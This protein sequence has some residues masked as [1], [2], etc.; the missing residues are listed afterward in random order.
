MHRK[1]IVLFIA[2][3][4]C[5]ACL[6]VLA[7]DVPVETY[8]LPNGL[9]VILHVDHKL[10]QATI[11]T[12]FRVGSKDE[13]KG[14]TG[15]AHLFEHLMF[16][17]TKRVP[18]GQFDV[19]M[20]SGG[21]ANNA[22]TSS[23]R[24]N[25]YS[26]GPSSLLPTLLWLD[27]DRMEGL[28]KAMTQEKLDLQR[29][30]VLNERRQS[31]ENRPYGKAWLIIPEALFPPGHP[32][33][34][35]VIG[36]PKD[37]EAATL[38]DVKGFFSTYYVPGNASLVV[39]GDFDKAAV[40]KVIAETFGAIPAQPLPPHKTAPPV[41]LDHEVRR[42]ATDKVKYPRI[43]LVWPSPRAYADGDAQMTLAAAILADG[44]SGRLYKR[45]V[46]DDRIAQNVYVYQDSRDLCSEFVIDVTAAQGADLG[47][48]KHAV[49]DEL[50]QFKKDG[51]T[52]AEMKRVKA[53]AEA[54]FLRM[55]ESL[56]RRADMLNE[57]Y[58][59]FGQ[60]NSFKRV[61][62][63]YTSA[64]ATSVKG[65]AGKVL[66][67]GRVDMRILPEGAEVKGADLDKRPA[68][69]AAGKV[70]T[71]VPEKLVLANGIPLY[72]VSRPGT[73]LFSGMILVNG[74]ERTVPAGKGGLSQLAASLL[75]DGAGKLDAS[76]YADAV[77]SL[78]ASVDASATWRDFR[79]RVSG[80]TS[81]LDPTLDLFADA[82]VR[83]TLSEKDFDRE[84][85][86]ALSNIQSRVERPDY[87]AVMAARR[88][89]F[90]RD[91][92]RG[93]PRA[94]FE[95]TV[96]SLSLADVKSAMPDLLNASNAQFLFVGDFDP[97]AL[98]AAL[99]KRFAAWNVKGDKAPALPAP[100]TRPAP[101]RLVLVDRPGAPQT[102]LYMMRPIEPKPGAGAAVQRESLN[103]LFGGAFTSRLMQNI[104]EKHGYSYGAGS[105]IWQEGNQFMLGAS[106][107]V[108]TAVTGAALHEFK[109]EFDAMATGDVT[110]KEYE[111]ARKTVRYDLVSTAGT[112]SSLESTLGSILSNGQPVDW[113]SQ[114]VEALGSLSL[115][116]AN[117][118]AKSGLFDWNKLLV[119]LVGDRKVV[120][121]QLEKEGFPAPTLVDAEGETVAPAK[122]DKKG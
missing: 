65:W 4:V 83:P 62:S 76:A 47:E 67:E 21:G 66:G 106:S 71:P 53:S 110:Q 105:M 112:T 97:Q 46:L 14:R 5:A 86:L 11:D 44:E 108:Q 117:A 16:M 91:D 19:I 7:Q 6:N 69:F 80:L 31:Y 50:A 107:S 33:H 122:Q 120:L 3:L 60:P 113:V 109:K 54:H 119:V 29:K 9:T 90:G 118:E 68:D 56:R 104:R 45:L 51:P 30:V 1:K 103:T 27:A 12:W 40:K 84:K 93:R 77:A 22:S 24:T 121:P 61:L 101:G 111:K 75:T 38:Q 41:V 20:E 89:I 42:M 63:M 15:F 34:H 36:S 2:A 8:T 28:G 102:V 95:A 96:R 74:G 94:G 52:Q 13:A 43:W 99:D 72:V 18:R 70:H 116:P 92:A 48:I 73:G 114:E 37:L 55:M 88:I 64:D 85:D 98:K 59:Y 10:P 57:F 78:G 39:A 25:Y 81:K 82:V 49:M 58:H 79:V 100:L 35:P 17:G 115:E 26:W 87:V 23:D 32:Y